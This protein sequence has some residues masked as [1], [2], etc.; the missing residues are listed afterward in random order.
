SPQSKVGASPAV[1]KP[2][3]DNN[4][5][6]KQGDEGWIKEAIVVPLIDSNFTPTAAQQSLCTT[7]APSASPSPSPSSTP[8]PIQSPSS[9][10]PKQNS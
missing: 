5:R 8:V 3:L 9:N 6:V 7:P 2:P 4:P 10:T 1:P